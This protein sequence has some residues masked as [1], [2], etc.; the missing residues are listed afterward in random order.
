MPKLFLVRHGEPAAGW[1][2]AADPGLSALG[3]GQARGAA[4]RLRAEGLSRALTSPLQRCRETAAPFEALTIPALLTPAVAEV[5]TPAGLS[6]RPAW[7]KGVM[8]GR[9][10]DQP[11]LAPWR[12]AIVETLLAQTEDIAVF[13]H[14]V[15][16]NVAVGAAL[17]RDDAVVFRPGHC[18][19]TVLETDGASLKLL[20]LG[21]EAAGPVL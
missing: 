5:P 21:E 11:G 10:A 14:F 7:L 6:D 15:A 18:S 17:G 3:A 16:I 20:A 12:A 13:S 9:W 4:Q 19:I 2:E 1:G 8:A